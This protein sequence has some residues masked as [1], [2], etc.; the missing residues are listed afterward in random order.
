MAKLPRLAEAIKPVERWT[1]AETSRLGDRPLRLPTLRRAQH[2]ADRTLLAKALVH[3]DVLAGARP[4][5][6]Q[7][8][9]I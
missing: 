5:R 1:A 8:K 3:S 9:T 4:A 7:T 2:H 6:K